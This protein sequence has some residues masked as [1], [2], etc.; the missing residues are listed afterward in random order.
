MPSTSRRRRHDQQDEATM[1]TFE[2]NAKRAR[3]LEWNQEVLAA[4]RQISMDEVKQPRLAA[5]AELPSMVEQQREA[6]LM[7]WRIPESPPSTITISDDYSLVSD[8]S[9]TEYI[10]VVD[11]KQRIAAELR[12]QR[13]RRVRAPS[14]R[15]NS[16]LTVRYTPLMNRAKPLDQVTQVTPQIQVIAGRA[17]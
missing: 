10:V 2:I 8:T 15:A 4:A 9:L 12:R 7:P 3:I 11:I 5:L 17:S 13:R 6:T 16:T 14:Q 1:T